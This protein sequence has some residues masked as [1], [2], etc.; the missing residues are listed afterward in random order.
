MDDLRRIDLNLLL[1]LHAL[2]AE[3][4]VTRAAT[5][6]HKSQPAI[7]HALAAA[8]YL[9]M[10]P[11]EQGLS[12]AGK[13]AGTVPV[14]KPQRIGIARHFQIAAPHLGAG[15][16]ARIAPRQVLT[17]GVGVVVLLTAGYQALRLFGVV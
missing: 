14:S 12:H 17:Y 6:L 15:R 5:R 13:S 16:F 10:L 4:H 11:D 8:M 2:L 7:S 9:A 1:S 3:K